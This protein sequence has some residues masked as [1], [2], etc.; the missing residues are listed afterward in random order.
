MAH[1]EHEE[2]DDGEAEAEDLD[3]AHG[4][5]AVE[6]D[7]DDARDVAGEQGDGDGDVEQDVRQRRGVHL[8]EG[9]QQQVE[10]KGDEEVSDFIGIV[11]VH[12]EHVLRGMELR[13]WYKPSHHWIHVLFLHGKWKI[14]LP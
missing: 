11:K 13:Q 9:A 6:W 14:L 5:D 8:G 7:V 1:A 12:V 3:A 10:G 2:A 4:I